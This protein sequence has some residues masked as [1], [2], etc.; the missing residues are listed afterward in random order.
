MPM[1]SMAPTD[2]DARPC[3]TPSLL[4]LAVAYALLVTASVAALAFFRHDMALI[5]PS[6]LNP[7]GPS[8][9]SRLFLV[10]NPEG[11]RASAFLCF[12]SAIPLSIYTAT[13]VG[14]LQYLGPRDAKS[15]VAFAGGLAASG[16]LAAAGLFLWVLSVPEA[17]A[18]V[19]VARVLHFLVF[20]TGGPAF[21]AG[22][23]LL[24]AGVSSSHFANVLPRWLVWLGL[25]IGGTGV[26]STLGLLSVPMTVA[27]PVTRVGGFVWLIAV[28]ALVPKLPARIAADAP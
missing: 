8:E 14:L 25:S 24:A 22:M 1:C 7:F 3:V 27:I 21:A 18:S 4:P 10:A 28:G 11:I 15:Y 5:G 23:G 13:I 9:T 26:L 2:S 16:G 6:A 20:L 19:P 12:A 17:A